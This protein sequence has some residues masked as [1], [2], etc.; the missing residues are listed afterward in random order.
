M[1][2]KWSN[3]SKSNL[4]DFAKNSKMV[5]A[6]EYIKALVEYVYC[7][8][9]QKYLGKILCYTNSKEIRQL[10]YKKHRILY[11]IHDD[12]IYIIAVIHSMQNLDYNIKFIKKYFK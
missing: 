9:E 6:L 4:K 11:H 10:I 12:E 2:I 8:S 7:L 5:S 1:V 3:F